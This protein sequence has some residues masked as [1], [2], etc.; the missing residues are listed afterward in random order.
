M[1]DKHF[2]L[3]KE[4]Q[5]FSQELKAK[6]IERK[7]FEVFEIYK[8]SYKNIQKHYKAM[9]VLYDRFAN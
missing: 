6:N 2:F 8:V 3:K 1:R 5:D 9:C 7:C 4:I